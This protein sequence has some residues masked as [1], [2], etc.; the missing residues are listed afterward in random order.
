MKNPKNAQARA[1]N[2]TNKGKKNPESH[3]QESGTSDK[4]NQINERRVPR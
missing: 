2:V 1:N 3:I 4:L